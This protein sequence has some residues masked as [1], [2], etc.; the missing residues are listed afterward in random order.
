MVTH[1]YRPMRAC[2][3]E[4]EL[5]VKV[6][7]AVSMLVSTAFF[8]VLITATSQVF[9][10]PQQTPQKQASRSVSALEEV[11]VT[12]RRTTESQQDVPVAVSALSSDD[13][14]RSQINSPTDLNGKVPS[15]VVGTGSQMRNTETPTIRGQGA[16]YGASPGVVIYISEV[17]LPSDPVANYQ[18]GEGKFFDL[19]NVQVLKGSQGTLFGRNTTGGALL[20]E[21]QKPHETLGFSLR[22][23]VSHLSDKL[24]DDIS[25]SSAEAVLNLP[26]VDDSLMARFGAQVFAR[27]GFTHDVVTGKDY[28]DKNYWAARAGLLWRPNERMEN[29]FLALYSDSNTNGTGTVI[30]RINRE[31]LNKAIPA[32]IGLDAIT[33]LIPGVDLAQVL[34]PGC[35]VLNLFGPSSNC[36]QDILDEQ[37][38]RGDRRVQ[39]SAKP[40][41]K[42]RSGTYLD[43]FSYDLSPRLTLRNI[44][45]YSTMDHVYRWDLDGSRAAF[46]EFTNPQDAKSADVDTFTEELQLQGTARDDNLTYVVGAYYERTEAEGEIIATSLFFVDVNQS[47][48]QTKESYAPFAQATYDLGDLNSALA[49]LNVTLGARYTFDETEGDASIRQLAAGALPLTDASFTA[50]VESSSLTYTAGLDYKIGNSMVYGKLSRGYKTGGISTIAVNPRNYTYDPEY[51]T[52]VEFGQKSEFVLANIPMRLNTA[53]YYTEYEDKQVSAP[54]AF[55]DPNEPSF[56]PKLGQANFNVADAWVGGVELDLTA[57]L[58]ESLVLVGSYAYTEAQ[59]DKFSFVY[60]GATPQRDCTGEDIES[61]NTVELSCVPFPTVPEHQYS[62]S[63]RYLFPFDPGIGDVEASLSYAW[64]DEQYS[65]YASAPEA[66]PGAWLPDYDLINASLRWDRINGSNVSLQVYGSNLANN[67]YRVSNS[68]QWNL[69]YMQSVMYSEPRKIGLE[70]SYDF[71]P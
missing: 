43:K 11:I 3:P 21:P 26:L 18:G 25:G 63:L 47:Y 17:A 68:N 49:G 58:T 46:N 2:C 45:S 64:V 38:A 66:E 39:L 44:I 15:L 67:K 41:D 70:V 1:R 65:A 55:V 40:M 13:L 48:Q 8:A 22:G 14:R 12:A 4:A 7:S 54:D 69:T 34:N 29:Y 60:E 51:V 31:G 59:Y 10:Q 42:L 37:A 35:L 30:K 62:V 50:E 19:A 5:L 61:G 9:G 56:V 16:Q 27:D 24:G 23:G 28:D 57:Q 71:N 33:S 20:L 52:S 6:K 53:L 36:G 32:S